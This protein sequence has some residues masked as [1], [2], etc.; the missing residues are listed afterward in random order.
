[1]ALLREEGE[2]HTQYTPKLTHAQHLP[3]HFGLIC[4]FALDL[5]LKFG[6]HHQHLVR[7][8]LSDTDLQLW[9]GSYGM[10]R[11]SFWFHTVTSIPDYTK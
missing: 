11:V 3:T 7:I 2:A 4:I 10:F 6:G 8:D 1:M 9:I 5:G